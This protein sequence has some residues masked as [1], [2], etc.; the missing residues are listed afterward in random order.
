MTATLSDR[1]GAERAREKARLLRYRDVAERLA[2]DVWTLEVSGGETRV[3]TTRTTGET[4]HLCTIHDAA[5]GPE[6]E[7]LCAAGDLLAFFLD[8]L[9]RAAAR[10]RT[11]QAAAEAKAQKDMPLA[12]RAAILC[13]NAQFQRFLETRGAGGPVRDKQAAD[14][15]LK[16][17]IDISSKTQLNEAG[18]AQ[19]KYF[20]LLD[21]FR[22]WKGGGS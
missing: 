4:V 11:L 20:R 22:A 19:R 12:S 2:G 10:V 15:R 8:L 5:L 13:Q 6:I 18:D 17:L 16:G 3:F 7:V 21:D 1:A 14:T 9:D